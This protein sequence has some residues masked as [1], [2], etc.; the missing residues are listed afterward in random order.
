MSWDRPA[1]SALVLAGG[2]GRRL[3]GRKDGVLVGGV[4]LLKRSL[5]VAVSVSDDVI[6]LPGVHL[7]PASSLVRVAADEPGAPGPLGALL[8]G[9]R[10][11]RHEA[12][13]L[14]P[15][16]MP[17]ARPDVVARLARRATGHALAVVVVGPR[18]REP[19]H[20]V[21]RRQA[22]DV[23][24][25]VVARGGRSLQ[26]VLDE[27]AVRGALSEVP[28]AE[29]QDLDPELA[30]LVNVNAAGDLSAA[31]ERAGRARAGA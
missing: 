17:F 14:L 22:A 13:L 11:A 6:L 18:G 28:A 8:G 20:A 9:L 26:E 30:F 12:S 31:N 7:L 21:W 3:G 27:L 4:P 16:D 10:A 2:A 5:A 1:L 25:E 19:F 23:V 15:C 29:M 24:R